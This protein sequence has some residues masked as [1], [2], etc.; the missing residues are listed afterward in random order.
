MTDPPTAQVKMNQRIALPQHPGQHPRSKNINVV[1]AQVKTSQPLELTDRSN[2]VAISPALIVPHLNFTMKCS[3][4]RRKSFATDRISKGAQ[5]LCTRLM[6]L[7]F[8]ISS[9]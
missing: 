9:L 4:K 1:P 6:L 8:P 7:Q 2:T 5:T 3:G